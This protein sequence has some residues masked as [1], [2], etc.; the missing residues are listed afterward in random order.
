[1]PNE[2]VN[3]QKK[4]KLTEEKNP[5]TEDSLP[6]KLTLKETI[7]KQILQIITITM[8]IIFTMYAYITLTGGFKWTQ[9]QHQQ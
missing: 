1:M 3:K 7:E 5:H 9:T 8:L 4:N 2:M 6:T